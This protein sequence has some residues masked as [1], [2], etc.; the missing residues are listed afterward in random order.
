[1]IVSK[2]F[3]G[4]DNTDFQWIQ[5]DHYSEALGIIFDACREHYIKKFEDDAENEYPEKLRN[6]TSFDHRLLQDFHDHLAAYWRKKF[7]TSKTPPQENVKD[8]L[9]WL[10]KKMQN[11]SFLRDIYIGI[12]FL[13]L[14]EYK[15]DNKNRIIKKL[16]F[17]VTKACPLTASDY[18]KKIPFETVLN[19]FYLSLAGLFSFLF[20]K[21]AINNFLQFP[22][23]VFVLTVVFSCIGIYAYRKELHDL[24]DKNANSWAIKLSTIILGGFGAAF[25]LS[26]LISFE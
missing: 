22:L 23:L 14:D 26:V 5:H 20:F 10:H 6:I 13:V 9:N 11:K 25:L 17:C 21:K 8:W 12:C 18:I 24:G 4:D 19:L 7:L 3:N 2:Y 15:E 16:Q 1:M